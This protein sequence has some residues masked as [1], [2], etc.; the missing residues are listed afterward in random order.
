MKILYAIQGTGN[1]HL[2][3]ATEIV[4]YLKE[5]ADTDVLVSGTQ[6]DL[7]LPFPV[8]YK[9]RGFSFI[10][11]KK[12]GINFLKTVT[13]F[14][15]LQLIND[16]ATLPVENYDLVLNDFEPVSAWACKLRGIKCISV[17]H[18]NAVLHPAAPRP[19]RTDLPG[20]LILNYYAP[21]KHKYGYHFKALDEKNFTPVIR[22]AIYQSKP[23]NKG[24]YTVY[25][26]AFSDKKIETALSAFPHIQWEVFSKHCKKNY[27]V[28]NITFS[29]VS[30]E[31]FNQSFIH[32]EGILCSA[33]FETPAEAL[34][35]GKKLCVVPMKNQYEQVCNGKM[36]DSLGI[37]VIPDLINSLKY[38][39]RWLVSKEKIQIQYPNRVPEILKKIVLQ[40][41][42]L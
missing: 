4:P 34:F 29:P 16:I 26:P 37:M 2:A 9:L 35:M 10:F 42:K 22:Q 31:K 5:I 11:G 39:Q 21:A 27:S 20:K 8:T 3:R 25:L 1:G 15:P 24:Y 30:L 33:G 32:C 12:G 7:N 6:G 28:N 40:E 14:S 23:E 38:I 19:E 18:Q 41:M 13:K 36:L 17:S